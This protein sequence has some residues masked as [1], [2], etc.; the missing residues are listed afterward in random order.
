MRAHH[1]S[2][3]QKTAVSTIKTRIHAVREVKADIITGRREGATSL[4]TRSILV[5]TELT[6]VR[7]YLMSGV[8]WPTNTGTQSLSRESLLPIAPRSCIIS[9]KRIMPNNIPLWKL[10]KGLPASVVPSAGTGKDSQ[11]MY[12]TTT[13]A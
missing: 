4:Q 10:E 9:S 13:A 8:I 1:T 5:M 11:Q 6:S 3:V 2:N 12:E 7:P